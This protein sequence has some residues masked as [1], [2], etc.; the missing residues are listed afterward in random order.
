[1]DD[2][3]DVPMYIQSKVRFSKWHTVT[4]ILVD[5][6]ALS[7]VISVSALSKLPRLPKITPEDKFLTG[8]NKTQLHCVGSCKL[9]VQ[10]GNIEKWLKWYVIKDLATTAILGRRTIENLKGKVDLKSKHLVLDDDVRIPLIIPSKSIGVKVAKDTV[11][12]PRG[13][14]PVP[15]KTTCPT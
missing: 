15:C 9:F 5:T 1:M 13:H 14:R 3:K 6:G 8:A 11:I 10:L 2:E 7:N 4:S 12:P